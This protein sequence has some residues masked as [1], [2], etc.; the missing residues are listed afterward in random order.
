MEVL[1]LET[2]RYAADLAVEQLTERGHRVLRCHDPGKPAFPC[3]ALAGEGPCPL[4]DPGVDVAL[5]VRAH[6]TARTSPHED[7]LACA[8]RAR[9]PLVVAGRVAL[10][11]YEEWADGVVDD[12]DVVG[13]CERVVAGPSRGHTQVARDALREATLRRAGESGDD[14][15]D[16]FVRRNPD[17]LQV[18]LEGIG[19]L[20]RS[21]RGL[22]VTDVAAALR[23][24]DAGARRIDIS[25]A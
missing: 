16:A 20:A 7:G 18:R 2:D 9:V 19:H 22:V 13:T 6:P 3:R 4:A 8:L 15:I 5:T 21:E 14:E 24:F 17:G 1:V 23:K 11:P 25:L 10:N 12:G